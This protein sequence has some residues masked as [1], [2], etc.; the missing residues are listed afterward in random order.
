MALESDEE[1]CMDT[2]P[3]WSSI[4][5]LLVKTLSIFSQVRVGQGQRLLYFEW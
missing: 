5:P 1:A 2:E 3:G 4:D